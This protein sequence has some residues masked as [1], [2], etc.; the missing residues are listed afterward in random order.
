MLE[1]DHRDPNEP[2]R[3]LLLE[4]LEYSIISWA[5]NSQETKNHGTKSQGIKSQGPRLGGYTVLLV[6][7]FKGK[8]DLVNG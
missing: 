2:I 6:S 5:F 1:R 4:Y 3:V 8:I 7:L